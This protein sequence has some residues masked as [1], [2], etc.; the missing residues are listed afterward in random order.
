MGTPKF[1]HHSQGA[2]LIVEIQHNGDK[3]R[4]CH[5]DDVA[6]A[7]AGIWGCRSQVEAVALFLQ[8]VH[9]CP[10][11]RGVCMGCGCTNHLVRGLQNGECFL[12]EIPT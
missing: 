5:N 8:L 9:F 3:V 2:R 11:S 1:S 12:E 4:T 6:P 10:R 7:I